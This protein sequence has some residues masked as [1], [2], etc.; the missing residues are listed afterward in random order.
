M[1]CICVSIPPA[2]MILPSAER[3]SVFAPIS[4]PA[5]I[6]SHRLGFPDFPIADIFH[7]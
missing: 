7:L 2:V 3:I 4:R 5:V 6:P 1:K